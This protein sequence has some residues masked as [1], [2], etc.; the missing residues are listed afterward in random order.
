MGDKYMHLPLVA[1][2]D[3][4]VSLVG[5][6]CSEREA[7]ASIVSPQSSSDES[8]HIMSFVQYTN[9]FAAPRPQSI[10]GCIL[11]IYDEASIIS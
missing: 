8:H 5:G 7:V 4:L 9:R 2:Y 1:C 10:A 11:P 3:W 6:P